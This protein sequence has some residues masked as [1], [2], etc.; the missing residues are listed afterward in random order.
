VQRL[1]LA[2]GLRY[3][4]FTAYF[5]EGRLGPVRWVPSPVVMPAEETTD[6]NDITVRMSAA[7]D[8]FGDGRTAVKV[9]L[10][11]YVLQQNSHNNALGG[12]A[13]PMNRIPISTNRSWNDANRN[14]VPDCDLL[15][16]LANAE[17][18]PWANRS[19]G[20]PVFET[21]LDPALT[22]GWGVRP[23]NWA[24]ETGVQRELIP[25]VSVNVTYFR[26]WYGNVPTTENRAAQYTFFDL[27]LPADPRLPTSGMVRG[28]MDV[29]PATFGQF[30][31]IVTHAK[32]FGKLIQNW[33]GVDVGAQARLQS[34]TIQGG[35]STGRLRRDICD[36]AAKNPTALLIGYETEL[37]RMP[38]GQAIPMQYCN[39]VGKLRTQVKG[40]GAYTIPRVDVSVAA[41]LQNI[42][43]QEVF[44][45]WAVP[46]AA[47]APLL[48]R[49]LAGNA[50]NI[51]LNLLPPQINYSDRM[52]Q[53]DV[54]FAKILR[55]GS[56]R[57][58]VTYDL[59]NALN[60]NVVQTYNPIYSPTGAWRVPTNI[61]SSRLSK[62]TAQVDF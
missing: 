45:T 16:P 53:L 32:N 42:P 52:T 5:P 12:Q 25:R 34:L 8:L 23:Y 35:V 20:T 39:M 22:H 48:G 3:D 49:N 44:A 61:L 1:T 60:S 40:L 43:G 11:K 30:D 51:S 2:G 36:V 55:F 19:F 10:G 9:A 29:T 24:F 57:L 58:Q 28:F 18:G 54:R 13:A 17:C 27:P 14:Y 26:R 59:Y 7:Y 37:G 21:R 62:I 33:H 50:A 6:Q 4:K 47:V 56:R 15:N 31:N 41:T 46:N 38:S